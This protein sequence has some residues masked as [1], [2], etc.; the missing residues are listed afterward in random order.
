M[1][2]IQAIRD[3]LLF[4]P[5]LGDDLMSWVPWLNAL[6][7]VYGLPVPSSARSLLKECTGRDR[8]QRKGGYSTALFLTGRRSGK[9]RIAAVIG[10]YEAA[11]AGHEKKLSKGEHG[12]VLICSPTKS[13]SRIVHGYLRA[14]FD[15][16]LLRQEIV[17]DTK[18]SSNLHGFELRNGNR[19][20][21]LAGDYRY[22]RGFT[23]VAAIVDEICFFGTDADT[24]LRSDTALIQALEP[25]L[26]TTQG[27]LIAISSPYAERGWTYK[28]FR[29]CHGNDQATTLV[30]K[31][32]SRTMNSTLPQQV[33]DERLQDDPQAGASEYLGEFRSDV[34]TFV[35]RDTIEACVVDGRQILRPQSGVTYAGFVDLSGGRSDDAGLAIAHREGATIVIDVVERYRPPFSPDTI[36]A[37]MV[38][39]LAEYRID[40]VVGQRRERY[41]SNK[42][43]GLGR[44]RCKLGSVQ[45]VEGIKKA[46]LPPYLNRVRKESGHECE[47]EGSSPVGECEDERRRSEA[48]VVLDF[49]RRHFGQSQTSWQGHLASGGVGS[50]GGFLGVEPGDFAGGSCQLGRGLGTSD[51]W[52]GASRL[53]SGARQIAEEVFEPVATAAVVSLAPLNGRM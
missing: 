16:P 6:R 41:F 38:Q 12:V 2:I 9:S 3:P 34:C 49:V 32:A 5:F 35:S 14:I 10:A 48:C 21:I 13:Q 19:I 37:K 44:I 51:L 53:V 17:R 50:T 15:A 26:L 33:I 20:E 31:C 40:K 7:V 29:Q 39:T 24:K 8:V 47:E 27:K 36:V 11:L 46:R 1:N 28:K 25:A 23:V 43:R 30:W 45:S 4:R 18:G 52:C 22:V 42:M